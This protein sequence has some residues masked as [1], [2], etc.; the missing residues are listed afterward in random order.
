MDDRGNGHG[1]YDD[2][3]AASDLQ[4]PSITAELIG[5]DYEVKKKF[6]S[7]TRFDDRQDAM[8]FSYLI[9][10][11]EKYHDKAGARY[12]QYCLAGLTSIGG[13]RSAQIVD[14]QT[15]I[16]RMEEE[17]REKKREQKTEKTNV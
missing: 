13:W 16:Q 11:A 8:D 14:I 6:L 9:A 15:Q 4:R 3:A 7:L 12:W 5:Q 10:K 17:K 2:M 1:D